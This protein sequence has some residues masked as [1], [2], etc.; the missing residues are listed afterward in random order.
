MQMNTHSNLETFQSFFAD[1]GL[2]I[3]LI[4]LAA[5]AGL[6]VYKHFQSDAHILKQALKKYAKAVEKDVVLFDGVDSY[7][8]ADYLV[9][10]QGKIVVI[11]LDDSDGYIFGAEN[12]HEWT[13]VKN[14]VTGKFANP[15]RKLNHFATQIK[16]TSAFDDVQANVLFGSS[17]SFPKGVPEHVLQMACLDKDLEAL[18]GDEAKH[19]QAEQAWHELIAMVKKDKDKVGQV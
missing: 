10:L 6:M 13:C 4:V 7:Q 18:V 16:Q 5:V 8:F 12:I 17:A 15:L 2:Y 9:L 14:N 11:K 3:G 1:Y 19:E